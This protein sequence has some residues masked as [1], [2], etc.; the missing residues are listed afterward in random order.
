MKD[1]SLR[2]PNAQALRKDLE[3]V[4]QGGRPARVSRRPIPKWGWLLIPVLALIAL[5][6]LWPV[7]RPHHVPASATKPLAPRLAVLPPHIDA[8]DATLQAFA[9]GL[10]A[11]VTGKLSSMSQNHDLEVIDTPRV[12]KAH[13]LSELGANLTL[14]LTVQQSGGMNRA[15]YRLANLKTGQTIAEETLTAPSSDPFSLQDRVADGVVRALQL[16]LRPEEKT[17]LAIHG[18]TEAAAYDYYLQSKGYLLNTSRPENVANAL[19]VLDRALQLDPSYGRAYAARGEAYWREYQASKQAKWIEQARQDCNHAVNLGNAGADGHLCLGLVAAGTGKYPEAADE[20]RKAVELDPTSNEGYVGL[21]N[22]YSRLN[23]LSDAE[24][25]Y[26]QAISQDPNSSWAYQQLGNFFLQQAQYGKAVEQFQAAIKLSPENYADYSNLGVAY[27]FM[28]N[29]AAAIAALEK[30]LKLR[31]AAGAYANLGTAYYQTRKFA[32][33]ASNYQQA[34]K[35]SDRDPD[36]WGNL[37]D[38]YQYGGQRSRAI[39]AYRRQ[40]QLLNQQLEVNP[41]DAE[42]QGDAA[43]CNAMLGNK[44]DAVAHLSRSLELGHGNKDLLFNAA[45]V[46]NDLGETGVALEWL[47]KALAAGYSASIIRDS[48]TFDNLRD[49]LQFQQLVNHPPAK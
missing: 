14:Q 25:A 46:Y 18:T 28:G 23:R 19:Q 22:A 1:P 29:Q 43:S 7:L 38:A 33:A 21:A 12:A 17:A 35:F 36:L 24:N 2:Y 30:S 40:L 9:D 41:Q 48:P 31:P 39:D 16:D 44:A 8:A 34:L 3:T 47:Q 13:G 10:S 49:N 26:R 27:L 37:A 20:Y 5:A 4:R 42:R 11:T 45:V 15:T 6:F 32:E